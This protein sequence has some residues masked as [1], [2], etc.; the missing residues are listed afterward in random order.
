[1][2]GKE[3]LLGQVGQADLADLAG[4]GFAGQRI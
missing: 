2:V 1:M 3:G 4:Y